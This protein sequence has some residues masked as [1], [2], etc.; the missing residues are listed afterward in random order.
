MI[1]SPPEWNDL[2]VLLALHRCG[3]LMAVGQ[4]LGISTST[5][6]RRIS[7][8]EAALDR[9]LVHRTSGGT[10]VVTEALDLVILAEQVERSLSTIS[11]DDHLRPM[12]GSV[13]ISAGE[14]FLRHLVPELTAFRQSNP[15]IALEYISESR[16]TDLANREADIG[17]RQSKTVSEQLEETHLGLI[18]F[19]LFASERYLDLR[20]PSRFLA[21]ADFALHD[22]LGFDGELRRLLQHRWLVERGAVRFPFRSNSQNALLV[23]ASQ[24]EG[25]CLLPTMVGLQQGLLEITTDAADGKSTPSVD[26]YLVTHRDLRS[27][28]RIRAVAAAIADGFRRALA[29]TAG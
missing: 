7:A 2:R 4:A 5:V 18:P 14:G 10:T 15:D 9:T 12:A 1:P 13:R 20:L 23:A 19:T 21:L 17:I 16:M 28:P 11:R 27:V 3:S 8:L 24:G 29:S 6:G 25:I 26:A 22:F